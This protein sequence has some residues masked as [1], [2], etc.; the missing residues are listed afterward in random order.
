[1]EDDFKR[2]V[3][4]VLVGVPSVQRAYLAVLSFDET[5]ARSVGLCIRSSGGPS[6]DLQV[7]LGQVFTGMMFSR[8]Q[9]LD[10]LFIGANQEVE[11]RKVCVPFYEN[12]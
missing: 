6:R 9:H 5:G 4:Q 10:I 11:L 2:L 1:V 7:R 12:V 3:K 8:S